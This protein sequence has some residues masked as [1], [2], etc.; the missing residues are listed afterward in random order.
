MLYSMTS[1]VSFRK[2]WYKTDHRYPLSG[3]LRYL[4]LTSSR[5]S[6]SK[7]KSW[8]SLTVIILFLSN[9]DPSLKILPEAHTGTPSETRHSRICRFVRN[10]ALSGPTDLQSRSV[11]LLLFPGNASNPT[12]SRNTLLAQSTLEYLLNMN[13][14]TSII[15]PI[16]YFQTA[17]G[18][19][20]SVL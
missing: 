11:A 8:Y 13:L 3:K 5:N 10:H 19:Q 15:N 1:N 9:Y 16:P 4:C 2:L 6:T 12:T 17:R 14:F 18:N 20:I 7:W